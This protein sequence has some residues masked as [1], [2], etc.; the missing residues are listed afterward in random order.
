MN[1]A[2]SPGAAARLLGVTPTTLRSWDRRYGIG[3]G[4][5]SPGGHRRYSPADMDRLRELCRLVG[6]GVPPATAAQRILDR[7]PAARPVL[8]AS[9]AVS[10]KDSPDT[11]ERTGQ[12]HTHAPAD[13]RGTPSTPSGSPA[14]P[15]SGRPGRPGGDTLPLGTASP[16]LQGIARAAMRMDSDLVEHLLQRALAEHGTV[17]VWENLAMPLLYGMGRK[18]EDTRRYVEVEHLLSWAVSS[19]LRRVPPGTPARSGP[20]HAPGS[21]R[22]VVLACAPH[23]MHSL[24]VEAL[25]AALREAGRAH[26]VLGPCTPTEAVVRTVRRTGP[27]A[28]VLWCHT[29]GEQGTGTLLAAAGAADAAREHVGLYTAGPGWRG[30]R[31]A[32]RFA[33]GHLGS[34]TEA[35]A[36]LAP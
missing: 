19:A 29:R 27:S 26:R 6:E 1:N 9:A 5:R 12:D 14:L 21:G 7:T 8:R 4:E 25:A 3:P 35:M 2:L 20:G 22:P 34:L 17:A 30:V 16:S 24:P 23:E 28:V 33:D 36:A 11:P 18:W 32:R 13:P 15:A 31:A 10:Q